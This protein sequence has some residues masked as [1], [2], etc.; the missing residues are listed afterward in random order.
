MNMSKSADAIL[1]F[2]R[3]CRGRPQPASQGPPALP[4]HAALYQPAVALPKA[5][6]RHDRLVKALLA[7]LVMSSIL[8][9]PARAADDVQVDPIKCW[10]RADATAVLVGERFR[11]TL[12]CGVVETTAVRTVPN[13]DALDPAA[14]SLT[15]FEVV[16]GTRHEDIVSPPWR[17]FQYEYIVRLIADDSFGQD[18][19]VPSLDV[20]YNIVSTS[21]ETEAREHRYRL[22][23]LP[24]RILSVVSRK[25]GDIRDR[26][27]DSFADVEDRRFRSNGELVVGAVSS[28]FALLFI[29]LALAHTL[30]RFR[31]R[32][33]TAIR[34]LSLMAAL[35]GSIRAIGEIRRESRDGWNQERITHALAALRV[36]AAVAS[37]RTVAQ[38]VVEPGTV[39]REGQMALRSG[40]LR[41]RS[42]VVSSAARADGASGRVGLTNVGPRHELGGPIDAALQAFTRARYGRTGDIDAAT[43]DAA[44]D[45][46]DRAMRTLRFRSLWMGRSPF[47][48][49]PRGA[50]GGTA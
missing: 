49:Q 27:Q 17:Y 24:M 5:G 39:A 14:L 47:A 16:G 48:R 28:G 19:E 38:T 12:T 37:G 50:S 44:L 3:T 15:P 36:A 34:A 7:L 42:L 41:R 8:L 9:Q 33:P 1:P 35:R 21:T 23:A 10:W 2:S 40:I 4:P 18:V 13:R 46:A 22:P 43:L 26:G 20:T 45:E 25:A 6:V 32:Q 11:L 31:H 29:G 30:G